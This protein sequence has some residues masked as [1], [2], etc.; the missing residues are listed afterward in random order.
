[1]LA[2]INP[3]TGIAYGIV[4][5]HL[6]NSWV[7]DEFQDYGTN[8]SLEAAQAEVKSNFMN[9]L[10]QDG[11]HPN[12]LE[13]RWAHAE[14]AEFEAIEIEEAC[15]TLETDGMK[16]AISWLG[17]APMVWVFFS[18]HTSEVSL[19]SPC[20]PN[21][22]DIQGPGNSGTEATSAYTLPP[23]WFGND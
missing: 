18:P 7:W 16:L 23:E 17:G 3:D 4:S 22:G 9:E 1:M 8:T 15:Y 6:L 11:V 20:C 10:L 2:N 12:A 5:M 13:E 14:D 19:C 21:A